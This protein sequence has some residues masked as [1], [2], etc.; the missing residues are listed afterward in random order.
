MVCEVVLFAYYISDLSFVGVVTAS[1][2]LR[3]GTAWVKS[4]VP[5]E[6]NLL[7]MSLYLFMDQSQGF[8]PSAKLEAQE[9]DLPAAVP[10]RISGFPTIKFKR[11]G[12]RDFIDYEG[13]RSFESLVAFLEEHA[14]NSLELPVVEIPQVP[15]EAGNATPHE[16]PKADPIEHV[17][18]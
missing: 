3:P 16:V 8:P 15:L 9:N 18:L 13:D 4:I 14:K 7:C 12:S 1:V 11:A 5:S 10:F 2:W 6:I 17:E